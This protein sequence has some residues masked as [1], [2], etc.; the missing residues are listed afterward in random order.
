M[1]KIFVLFLGLCFALP[2]IAQGKVNF[3]ISDIK[4]GNGHVTYTY[5]ID[6]PGKNDILRMSNRRDYI[7]SQQK[8][9]ILWGEGIYLSTGKKVDYTSLMDK[10]RLRTY[11][12]VTQEDYEVIQQILPY[13]DNQAK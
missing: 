13:C 8:E 12:P 5:N 2:I 3:W 11:Q 9:A 1:K 6:L 10:S 4:S 7:C